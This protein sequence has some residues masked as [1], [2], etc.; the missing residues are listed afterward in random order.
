M[1]HDLAVL[2]SKFVSLK[3]PP[4]SK[5]PYFVEIVDSVAVLAQPLPHRAILL[6]LRPVA[7]VK[8]D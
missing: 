2:Q 3:R 5:E 7:T 8:T 6:L 4:I 1:I